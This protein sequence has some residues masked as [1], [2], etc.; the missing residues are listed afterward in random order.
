MAGF[1]QIGAG[2]RPAT[3]SL[4]SR[5]DASEGHIMRL[6]RLVPAAVALLVAGPA[7]GQG[8]IEYTSQKDFFSINFPGEPTV[9]D[10]TYKSHYEGMYPAREYSWTDGKSKYIITVVDYRNAAEIFKERVKSCAPDAQSDCTE[11]YWTVDQYAAPNH[12]ANAFL[13]RAAKVTYFGYSRIDIIGGHQIQLIEQDGSRTFVEIHMHEDLLYIQAATVP[14]G[15]P[16]PALFGQS[17]RILD[18]QGRTVRYTTDY[19]N[20]YPAP[21]RTGGGGGGGGGGQGGGAQ[22]GGGGN[23]P[24][25]ARPQ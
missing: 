21:P 10:I 17:L 1:V 14:A 19:Y 16:E 18:E 7:F 13:T 25:G 5:A 4:V 20:G 12:A 2:T 22:Q 15:A 8:W 9:R 6:T 3:V 24:G 11:D 23:N